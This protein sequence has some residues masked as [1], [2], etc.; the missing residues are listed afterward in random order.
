M[1]EG[2]GEDAS[3]SDADEEE[4]DVED[5]G[6]P[7]AVDDGLRQAAWLLVVLDHLPRAC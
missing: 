5:G 6:L 3:D 1:E 7:H 4:Q 2:S